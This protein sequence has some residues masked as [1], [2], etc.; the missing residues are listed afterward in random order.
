MKSKSLLVVLLLVCCCMGV[1][2]GDTIKG[3]SDSPHYYFNGNEFEPITVYDVEDAEGNVQE[4]IL[5]RD[6]TQF[7]YSLKWE[8][9]SR[10]IE[11]LHSTSV[12]MYQK[13]PEIRLNTKLVISDIKTKYYGDASIDTYIANGLSFIKLERLPYGYYD[14]LPAVWARP[15]YY[16]LN[17]SDY[18]YNDHSPLGN[19]ITAET[20]S[21]TIANMLS[22]ELPAFNRTEYLSKGKS[23]YQG[24]IEKG[25]FKGVSLNE[26]SNLSREQIAVICNNLLD[27]L[28]I[29]YQRYTTHSSL[30]VDQSQVA[31]NAIKSI[32]L[33]LNLGVLTVNSKAEINPK[34]IVST[35]EAIVILS[36]MLEKVDIIEPF[37][38]YPKERMNLTNLNFVGGRYE[39]DTFTKPLTIS[40]VEPKLTVYDAFIKSNNGTI[41]LVIDQDY[42]AMGGIYSNQTLS[43]QI[44]E[45]DVVLKTGETIRK[46]MGRM[47]NYNYIGA[48]VYRTTIQLNPPVQGMNESSKVIHLDDIESIILRAPQNVLV[49]LKM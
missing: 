24:L 21:V 44:S 3:V 1:S 39:I 28:K 13:P 20:F 18:L 46:S 42:A 2:F 6:L 10:T 30:Y 35:Q 9:S 11:I 22:N 34:A 43:P 48:G 5:L 19:K 38:V 15:Y 17:A 8:S 25:I 4:L 27:I 41:T 26:T 40:Q 12:P 23:D 7:G 32:D 33:L 49:K 47:P 45:V 14:Y 16:A 36:K 31:V 37:K 29:D